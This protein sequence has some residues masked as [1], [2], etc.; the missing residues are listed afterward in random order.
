MVG[1]ISSM[2]DTKTVFIAAALTATCVIGLTIYACTTSSDL[3]MC[4]GLLFVATLGMLVGGILSM[5]WPNRILAIVLSFCGIIVFGLHIVY[6]T[7]LIMGKGAAQFSLD[8]YILAAMKL[9]IDIIQL[10]LHILRL[11]SHFK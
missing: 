7:Q 4:G 6:D 8:D 10:F 3:T 1:A 2:T 11:L 5:F 9:Y